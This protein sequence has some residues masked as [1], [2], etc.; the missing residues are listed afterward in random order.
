MAKSPLK[1]SAKL[2]LY[3]QGMG[4]WFHYT[5]VG[6]AISKT[7]IC[8]SEKVPWC[9]E[10]VI[11]GVV[12]IRQTKVRMWTIAMELYEKQERSVQGVDSIGLGS[13]RLKEMLES[14]PGFCLKYVSVRILFWKWQEAST[15][16]IRQSFVVRIWGNSQSQH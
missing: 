16:L 4:V 12:K 8:I 15:D 3:Q 1:K 5:S 6:V 2:S 10:A 14:S 9:R 13:K 11:K 7:H